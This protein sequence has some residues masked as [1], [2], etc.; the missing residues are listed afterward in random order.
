MTLR[1]PDHRSGYDPTECRRSVQQ[2][3]DRRFACTRFTDKRDTRMTVDLEAETLERLYLAV[4]RETHILEFDDTVRDD[5]VLAS[6]R[7]LT[8]VFSSSSV[9]SL[10]VSTRFCCTTR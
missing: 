3:Q 8:S 2:T 4:V 1:M 10:S 6:G 5:K 9:M 7:S